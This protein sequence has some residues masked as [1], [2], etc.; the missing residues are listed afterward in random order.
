MGRDLPQFKVAGVLAD[1]PPDGV[2]G[3]SFRGDDGL[4]A[5]SDQPRVQ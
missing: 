5:T 4:D 3:K 2:L 1:N